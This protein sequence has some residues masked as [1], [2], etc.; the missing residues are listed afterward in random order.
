[1]YENRKMK[2]VKNCLKSGG[3]RDKKRGSEFD[4]STLYVLWKYH[5]ETS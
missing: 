3:R 2:P 1:M 4:Q 5:N